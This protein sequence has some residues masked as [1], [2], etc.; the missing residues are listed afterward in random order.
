MGRGAAVFGTTVC[1]PPSQAE[2]RDGGRGCLCS[3]LGILSW[4]WELLFGRDLALIRSPG[5]SGRQATPEPLVSP[6]WPTQAL[7]EPGLWEEGP[8]APA[9]EDDCITKS[10]GYGRITSRGSP[11]PG[12]ASPCPARHELAEPPECGGLSLD[13]SV[14]NTSLLAPLS[15]SPGIPS[16]LA[17]T[18][19]APPCCPTVCTSCPNRLRVDPP[20]LSRSVAYEASGCRTRPN[21]LSRCLFKPGNNDL[22]EKAEG[23]AGG[24]YPNPH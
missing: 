16:P 15:G 14:S 19:A 23:G 1:T 5:L 21:K 17:P 13:P 9:R 8:G 11:G 20:G 12:R 10:F 24:P 2:S 6:V 3:R 4:L 22:W 7:G 18:Q